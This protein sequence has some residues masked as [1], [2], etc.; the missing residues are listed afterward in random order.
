MSL[1][2]QIAREAYLYERLVSYRVQDPTEEIQVVAVP[3]Q[4]Q[5]LV[6]GK[7]VLDA[8]IDLVD[9]EYD[10]Y[11]T[12]R[13]WRAVDAGMWKTYSHPPGQRPTLVAMLVVRHTPLRR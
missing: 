13:L 3:M 9:W 2:V 5:K 6:I 8:V 1:L 4:G 7:E 10:Q 11:H 12:R